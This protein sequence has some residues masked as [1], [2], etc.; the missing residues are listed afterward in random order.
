MLTLTLLALVVLVAVAIATLTRVSTRIAA[1][2]TLQTQARQ[3][4]LVGL[5]VAIGELQRLAGV[6]D[7]VTGRSSVRAKSVANRSLTGVWPAAGATELPLNWLVSGNFSPDAARSIDHRSVPDETESFITL[8]GAGSV[9]SSAV[10]TNYARAKKI[11]IPAATAGGNAQH[12]AFWIGDE[13]AKA[14]LAVPAAEAPVA[15]T[16]AGLWADPRGELAGFPLGSATLERLWTL[17]QLRHVTTGALLKAK[18]HD[19]AI[20]A[21]WIDEVGEVRSGLFNINTTSVDSWKAVLRAYDAARATDSSALAG[22]VGILA[23]RL[24][25]NMSG[26]TL[27]GQ[28]ARFGP[29]LSV[30]GFWNS[31]IVEDSLADVGIDDVTQEEIRVVLSPMLA[32][33]SDTFRVRAYGDAAGAGNAAPEAV[34]YC[35]AIVQRTPETIDA[36]LGRRFVVVS[37]RWLLPDDV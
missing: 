32:V 35:E 29:F 36:T 17:E 28:K 5:G 33:R 11:A 6:D 7:V 27:S 24:T 15:E 9:T 31:N 21:R 25:G 10:A 20:G 3:N 34:A 30:V 2:S 23:E 22:R 16:G 1:T 8:V 14:A 12:Y 18:F 4:A 37:F 26:T 19:Y 13:G